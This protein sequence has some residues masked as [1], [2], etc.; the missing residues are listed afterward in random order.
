ME[1]LAPGARIVARDA[2]WLVKSTSRTPN[3]SVVIE[4]VGVSDFIKGRTARFVKELEEDLE[5]LDPK[6]TN[7]VSDNTPG[8]RN[9]LLF[10]EAHLRQTAPTETNLYIGHEAAMD[11]LPYQLDPTLKALS[12]P[13]QRLLIADAVG[14]GKTLEAGI[15]VAEL[16]RRGR[17]KRILVVTTKSMLTQFQKE[18][19]VRFTIPL[20]RLDSVGIQRIRSR[21]PTNHNPFHYYDKAIVSVDTLKQDREYRTYIEQAYWDVI[22]IDE[23]HNVARRGRGSS[24]SLR[25]KLADRLASR[26]DSLIM[27]SATPHDGRAESFASLMNMLDPTAIANESNY[28]K[29]DIRDLYVRRFKKDV[30]AQLL[31]KFPERQVLAVEANASPQEEKAFEILDNLK[32]AGID[33]KASTGKLFKTTLLKAMLSS[34]MAC[35]ETVCNRINRVEKTDDRRFSADID[36][37]KALAAALVTIND[38]N[39][40]KYQK[41]L[42]LIITAEDGGFAWKGKDPKDRIVIFTERLET[43]RF[44]KENL[45]RDLQLTEEAI[46]TLDGG[47]PDV[48]LMEI[49]EEFG[50][51]KSPLRLVVAT[52]VASEG[53]NL[54]YFSHR[55]IH[56]DIPWSLMALQQRNGRVDRYG[57]ERQPQIRYLLTRSSNEKVDEAERIVSVLVRKDEQAIKNIGDPSVFMGVFDADKEVEV[58]AAA[59]EA[60]EQGET[61]ETF[62][63]RLQPGEQTEDEDNW[64]ADLLSDDPEVSEEPQAQ[65]AMQKMP[66]LFPDDYHYT[67]AAL[68][69]VN[70]EN[71]L[72]LRSL[73]EELLIELTMPNELRSRFERLP[74]EIQPASNQALRL[75][76]DRNKVMRE[77]EESRKSEERWPSIQYLWEL[78]PVV[79]WLNDRGITLFGRHQAPVIVLPQLQTNEVIFVMSGIIPNRRGQPLVNK[80]VSVVFQNQ[81][82]KHIEDFEKTLQLTGLGEEPIPNQMLPT[83]EKLLNLREIAVVEAQKKMLEARKNFEDSINVQLQE[84]L[85][86]LNKLKG[87]HYE[88]LTLRFADGTPLKEEKKSKAE[89]R[90]EQIFNDYWRWVEDSMTTEPAPYIKIIAVLQGAKV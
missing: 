70:E 66:S 89:R 13:R 52:D 4:V 27:L 81:K 68:G 86:R 69:A 15:L 1:T 57:Q 83:D 21:I 18:F 59:I 45:K 79:D 40:S 60:I 71:P 10:L 8:Y 20:V 43:M 73:G 26:S 32:L 22:V 75:S 19:W 33:A 53:I 64:F 46:A 47:M 17:A 14:L 29:E 65:A 77:L 82:F 50:S 67:L 7:L 62:D 23:A 9:S 72:Q 49:I 11:V 87:Q 58:T 56:F 16:M 42:K 25:S 54:H 41:L 80:W 24:A 63:A 55:L 90:I 51:E 31:K 28:T 88:Q 39:F 2:E 78:H 61:A 3:G 85:N 37:L 12:M 48:E 35:L 38:Q 36:E 44:L 30:V 6:N 5:V 76:G 34:P 74:R 84:Q